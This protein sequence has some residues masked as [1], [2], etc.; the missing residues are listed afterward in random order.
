[1]TGLIQPDYLLALG[2]FPY[3]DS[4]PAHRRGVAKTADYLKQSQLIRHKQRQFKLIAPIYGGKNEDLLRKSLE[5]VL[6]SGIQLDGV[7]LCL[8][9]QLTFAERES[10][11]ERVKQA[12]R[13]TKAEWLLG[14]SGRGR[15]EVVEHAVQC[16]FSLFEVSYPFWLADR[17]TA[18]LCRE[19]K[20]CEVKPEMTTS[21]SPL[22][23]S[24]SCYCCRR[25]SAAYVG[26]LC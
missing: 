19:G 8:G 12:M 4:E 20:Y 13:Q 1:M 6:G 11:Y 22:D 3:D 14:V 25:H 24:C 21:D 18:L 9:E 5:S 10:I 17:L 26:Y 15:I 7:T 23:A 16:G 2:E